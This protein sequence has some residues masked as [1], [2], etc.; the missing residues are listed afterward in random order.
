MVLGDSSYHHECLILKYAYSL[1]ERSQ[2]SVIRMPL[3]IAL[4]CVR[5]GWCF[6]AP[7]K[8]KMVLFP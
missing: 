3:F 1:L 8:V 2:C 6:V 4:V 5:V 7:E